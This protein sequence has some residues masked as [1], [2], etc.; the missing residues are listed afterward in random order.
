MWEESSE[1]SEERRSE[2]W[3]KMSWDS[4]SCCSVLLWASFSEALLWCLCMLP[5]A[6]QGKQPAAAGE[7]LR[8]S[9][10]QRKVLR[11]SSY[12]TVEKVARGKCPPQARFLR[13]LLRLPLF[14][15]RGTPHPTHPFTIT[16]YLYCGDLRQ[17]WNITRQRC[18]TLEVQATTIYQKLES[19]R[20]H[21]ALSSLLRWLPCCLDIT[22]QLQ[23]LHPRS[24]ITLSNGQQEATHLLLLQYFQPNHFM[25]YKPNRLFLS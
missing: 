17:F 22:H 13:P 15:F 7:L 1:R 4:G 19:A 20:A 25:S 3:D 16:Q 14:T 8:D 2:R 21:T 18:R 6:K 23:H 5:F 10:I 12:I 9:M 11:N 24:N